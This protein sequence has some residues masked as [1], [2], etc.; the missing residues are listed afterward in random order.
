MPRTAKKPKQPYLSPDMA[1]PSIPVIDEA[2]RDYVEFRDARMAAGKDETKAHDALLAL[3][4]DKGLA[5]YA[6]EEF[7]VKLDSKTKVKVRRKKESADG[8][9]DEE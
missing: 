4:R 3:M 9:D 1:P 8:D 7:T 2:A 6:F 5:E